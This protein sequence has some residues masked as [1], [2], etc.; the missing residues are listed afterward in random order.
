[1]EKRSKRNK[2]KNDLLKKGIVA[3]LCL[4]AAIYL[5]ISAYFINHFY[6]GTTINCVNVS[7]K[8]VNEANEALEA[9]MNNYSIK[10]EG[11]N[12]MSDEIKGSDIDLSYDPK[13]QLEE[14]KKQQNPL[15]WIVSL[16][17]KENIELNGIVSFND[18]L[19]NEQI[20]NLSVVKN[21]KVENPQNA[22]FK[23]GSNGFEIVDEVKGN[24]IDIDALRQNVANA[25]MEGQ[26]TLD[27]DDSYVKPEYT[28]NSEK[29]A[30]AKDELNGYVK[31]KITYD[32]GDRN[33]VLDGSTISQWLDVDDDMNVIFNEKKVYSYVE[34]LARKYNTF[35]GNRNFTTTS[36]KQITV[37]GGNYGWIID[38][39]KEV[40][41]LINDIKEGKVEERQPEYSQTAISRDI[42][43]V[44]NTYVEIDMTQQHL[45]YYKDGALVADGDVVTGNKALNHS[46]PVGTYRI[47]YKEKNATL[48]GEDYESKVTYW[49]PFNGNIGVHDAIWRDKFGGQIYL[50]NGS[51]GCVN[52]PYA[53]AEKIFNNIEAGIPV[54]CYY[55]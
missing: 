17:K 10:L 38:K 20:D 29:T 25:I 24:K 22:S 18:T 8:S 27:L 28:A 26:E 2:S 40:K 23:Y 21:K 55:E 45:W 44:G 54:I 9:Q 31:A 15:L 46:T 48:K 7:G 1:M 32:F 33:E 50:T 5:G 52:A 53:L 11:R 4:L 43:D 19:L 39:S 6:F 36:G 47:T 37:S 30:A 41:E 34:G 42:D 13:G 49:M 51:H 35:G 12:N 14:L 16:F 3:S